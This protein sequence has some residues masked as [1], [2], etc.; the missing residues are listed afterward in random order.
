MF[1]VKKMHVNVIFY[2]RRT[3]LK[4]KNQFHDEHFIFIFMILI[5]S[6]I[7][8]IQKLK[9][10]LN[11]YQ[12]TNI[13]CPV[14]RCGRN[15]FIITLVMDVWRMSSTSRRLPPSTKS[16]NDEDHIAK[17]FSQRRISIEVRTESLARWMRRMN[18]TS[19]HNLCNIA[20]E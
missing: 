8:N 14:T 11:I 10:P 6:G 12:E 5:K 7:V 3:C 19:C 18:N 13:F 17:A 1:C 4:F 20:V 16:E 2:R 9:I 15:W